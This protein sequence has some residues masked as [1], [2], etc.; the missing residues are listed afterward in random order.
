MIQEMP[1]P[2]TL[3]IRNHYT[4]LTKKYIKHQ[5]KILRHL[6]KDTNVKL[7]HLQQKTFTK[8][9]SSIFLTLYL[10]CSIIDILLPS[11]YICRPAVISIANS[12]FLLTSSRTI[13]CL[14]V[15][16]VIRDWIDKDIEGKS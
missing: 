12:R 2:L 16:L 9:T 4:Y 14:T 7:F 5:N 3:S 8:I 1:K 13:L 15:E 10:E 11:V 6:T